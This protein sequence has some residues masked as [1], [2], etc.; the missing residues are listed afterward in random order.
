[1]NYCLDYSPTEKERSVSATLRLRNFS[2]ERTTKC[3]PVH[4]EYSRQPHMVDT[5]E[6]PAIDIAVQQ[7]E[8]P[9]DIDTALRSRTEREE[10]QRHE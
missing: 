6:H 10:G 3:G 7:F 4:K 5:E 2:P 8:P 9:T 1:M